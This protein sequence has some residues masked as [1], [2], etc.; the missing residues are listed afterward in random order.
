MAQTITQ[1]INLKE[2]NNKLDNSI[3][4]LKP[5]LRGWIHAIATPL[6][7]ASSIVLIV[8]AQGVPAKISV[9]VFGIT[10]LALFGNS[11]V[12]HIGNGPMPK[13]VTAILRRIDHA[14][15]FLIIAGTYTPLGVILLPF[16]TAVVMLSIVWG[17]AILGLLAKIFWMN[18]PRW[19]YVPV[20]VALGWVAIAYM[21]QI[22]EFGGLAVAWLVVGGGI[23]YTLG[24]AIYGIKKP[25][26]SP[27]WFGFHEIFHVFTVL[28]F[29]AHSVAIFIIV[30]VNRI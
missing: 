29:A 23:A 16:N 25:N 13:K 27:K 8:L 22:T 12:Y 3:S 5:K 28:G 1:E 9:I 18:A 24:A 2:V 15:I 4:S 26:P 10:A 20:Y 19:L 7:L 11:A 17:G 6:V 21:N 30:I 14:N